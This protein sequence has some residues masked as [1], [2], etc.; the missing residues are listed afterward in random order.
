MWREDWGAIEPV[1]R[2]KLQI[3]VKTV[4]LV[5]TETPPCTDDDTCLQAVRDLQR[6]QI[7]EGATDIHWKYVS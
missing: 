7:E 6:K 2:H 3:P 5:Y 4:L 1:E